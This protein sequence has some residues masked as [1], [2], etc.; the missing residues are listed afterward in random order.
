MKNFKKLAAAL[1][2]ALICSNSVIALQADADGYVCSHGYS[3]LGDYT[4]S[5]GTTGIYY[6][7]EESMYSSDNSSKYCMAA[8]KS[9]S[10]WNNTS[11]DLSISQTYANSANTAVIRF[12]LSNLG[13]YILGETVHYKVYAQ[14]NQ[15]V[16]LNSAGALVSDYDLVTIT[17][18]DTLMEANGYDLYKASGVSAH[19]FG[20]AVGLSHRNTNPQSLMCQTAYGRA[21]DIPQA[22]DVNTFNHLY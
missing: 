3:T 4:L 5:S 17:L 14:Y 6:Q 9:I 20:H 10:D 19:E 8:N 22:I 12:H 11:A 16:A 7:I 13:N 21:V 15:Q 18:N 2:A 1:T